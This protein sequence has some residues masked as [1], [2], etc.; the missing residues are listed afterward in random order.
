M[1]LGAHAARRRA[2]QTKPARFAALGVGL[3]AIV[4][5]LIVG[6]GFNVTV[7][8]ALAFVFSASA[9]FP[10][11]L[12]ALTWKRFNTT[13]ALTG[14]A[15]GLV[16]SIVLLALSP[17][18]WPG[19]DS[20]GSPSPLIFPAI[21]TVPLG[22]LGCWLGTMLSGERQTERSYEELLVRSEIGLGSEVGAP[23]RERRRRRARP[24]ET[25]PTGR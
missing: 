7:L 12:L 23:A 4:A 8:V 18:I 17:P 5:T 6:S 20:E 13:G 19:P 25:A 15:F 11:L 3:A 21:F 22:F 2:K 16:S 1:C 10:P 9:N 14:I 24:A